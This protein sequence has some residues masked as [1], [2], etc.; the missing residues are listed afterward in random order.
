MGSQAGAWEPANTT[1]WR[2]PAM[3]SQAG[4][5]V[6]IHKSRQTGNAVIPAGMQESGAMD[7][8]SP[9]CQCLIQDTHQ[10]ADSPPCDWIPAVHAGMTGLLHLCITARAGAWGPRKAALPF[11]ASPDR[12]FQ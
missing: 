12:P 11:K 3:G 5:L 8:N 6:V 9:L 2:L 1:S 4:A 7:G 10:P